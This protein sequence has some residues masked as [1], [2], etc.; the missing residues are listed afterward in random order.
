MDRLKLSAVFAAAVTGAVPTFAFPPPTTADPVNTYQATIGT[1]YNQVQSYSADIGFNF[2]TFVQGPDVVWYKYVSDGQ[3]AVRFDTLNS[4]IT[5][6]GGGGYFL[7]STNET[8]V[9]VY[10]SSGSLVALSKNTVNLNGDPMAIYPTFSNDKGTGASNTTLGVNQ[11]TPE[12]LSQ[13]Y[14]APTTSTNPHWS[15]DPNS[16]TYFTG[17]AAPGNEGNSQKYYQPYYPTNLNEYHVWSTALSPIMLDNNGNPVLDSNNQPRSQPGWRYSDYARIGPASTWNRYQTL[18]AGTYYIAVASV[19]PTLAGDT[20]TQAVLEAPIHYDAN[21]NL[22]NQPILTGP[23]GTWQYYL[24][25]STSSFS[26]TIQLDVTQAPVQT[27][28]VSSLNGVSNMTLNATTLVVIN[29]GTYGGILQDGTFQG[30]LVLTGG[31]L[32][33]TA[34][35]TLSGGITLAGGEL[36]VASDAFLGDPTQSLTFDGGTLG[37]TGSADN[38]TARPIY[39]TNTGGGFD[40]VDPANTFTTAGVLSGG[41][42]TKTGAGTL[43]LTKSYST[44]SPTVVA[45]GTLQLSPATGTTAPNN[46]SSTAGISGAGNLSVV[47][48]AF[49]ISDGITLNS[50]SIGGSVQIRSNGSSTG[51][52]KVNALVLTGGANAWT[53]ALDLTNNKLIIE[54]NTLSRATTIAT[55]QDQINYGK[56][57]NAGIYSSTALPANV[58]MALLDNSLL[59]KSTFGG[60]SV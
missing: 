14:L 44:T 47:S 17:W 22:A 56:T 49:L 8:Q 36:S 37:I 48:G 33:L 19:S 25:S 11:Y 6:G 20:Y 31:T 29:G 18:P 43:V 58:T 7:P 50:L 52:T 10:T 46:Y 40:I 42:L 2:N 3:T 4:N 34:N 27:E 1:N 35:N 28:T 38:S 26:G 54:D 57:H 16:T 13:F 59:N 12:E 15:A 39:W 41:G 9:A 53:G 45:A 51:T 60:L 30:L 23:L 24:D 32:T 5:T 21:A 55:L